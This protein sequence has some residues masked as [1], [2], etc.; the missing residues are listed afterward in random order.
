MKNTQ[1][2]SGVAKFL[3]L[4]GGLN[5]GLVGLFNFDLVKFLLGFVGATMYANVA[6]VLVGISALWIV[7]R[8]YKHKEFK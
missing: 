6:Y 1:I 5:W 2:V 8:M 4:L 3:L 7:W